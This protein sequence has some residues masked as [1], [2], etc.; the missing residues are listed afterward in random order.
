MDLL[1]RMLGHEETDD[2]RALKIALVVSVPFFVSIFKSCDDMAYHM[3][4]KTT[5]AV[6][7]SI[8]EQRSRYGGLDGYN[9]WYTFVNA[10]SNKQ[11]TGKTLV[12][13]NQAQEYFVGRTL[14]IEYRGDDLFSSRIKGSGGWFWQ[15]F[16]VVWLIAAAALI[17]VLTVRP[18]REEQKWRARHPRPRAD[19]RGHRR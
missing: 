12:G 10:N 7:S 8:A 2:T 18:S 6:V 15:T 17:I 9:V 5:T 3:S 1:S 11:V 13:V 4:G 19:D 14:D 16:L